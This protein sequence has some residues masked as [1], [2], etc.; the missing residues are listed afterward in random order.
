MKRERKREREGVGG[1]S[2]S[3]ATGLPASPVVPR[4]KWGGRPGTLGRWDQNHDQVG[5]GGER[6][7]QFSVTPTFLFFFFSFLADDLLFWKRLFWLGGEV[8]DLFPGKKHVGG[9]K[10][11]GVKA[12]GGGGKFY[13]YYYYY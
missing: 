1:L 13:Y 5:V 6:E 10:E 11:K 12:K 4:D 3:F 2:S 7:E 8:S 9:S